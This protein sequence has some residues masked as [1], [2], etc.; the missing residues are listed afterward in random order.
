MLVLVGLAP[1]GAWAQDA[2]LRVVAVHDGRPIDAG[3]EA[4]DGYETHAARP[5]PL[6]VRDRDPHTVW[7]VRAVVDCLVGRAEIVLE[8]GVNE[9]TVPLA[10]VFDVILH[11]DVV[12]P[13]GRPVPDATVRWIAAS[14]G[15]SPVQVQEAAIAARVGA[16]VHHLVVSAPGRVGRTVRVTLGRGE[17]RRIRV[18]LAPEQALGS[19]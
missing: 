16:G 15:C 17:E 19:G 7:S 4:T 11:V 5:G 1:A 6:H 9:L 13:A 18:V 10:P 2:E 14:H 3:L 8:E 12:D